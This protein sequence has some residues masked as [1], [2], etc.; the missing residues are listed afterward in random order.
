MKSYTLRID[1]PDD[2]ADGLDKATE[3]QKLLRWIQDAFDH[4]VFPERI[5]LDEASFADFSAEMAN[6]SEPTAA[7]RVLFKHPMGSA[8][9]VAL[10]ELP[11]PSESERIGP[12]G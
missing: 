4:Y 6:P 9:A 10:S 5:V 7:L 8:R 11:E 12:L 3:R 2:W 1:L